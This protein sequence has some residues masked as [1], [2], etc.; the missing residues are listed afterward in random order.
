MSNKGNRSN[1]IVYLDIITEV[2]DEMFRAETNNLA[3]CSLDA[4]WDHLVNC[5]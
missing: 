5:T 2:T 1:F 4:V 3:T